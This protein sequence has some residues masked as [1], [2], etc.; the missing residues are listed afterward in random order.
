MRK[1]E[2]KVKSKT[3]P[4]F[5]R[6]ECPGPEL[7]HA[8]LSP[9]GTLP[10]GTTLLRIQ[11]STRSRFMRL[12]AIK[13]TKASG[14]QTHSWSRAESPGGRLLWLRCR[15]LGKTVPGKLASEGSLPLTAKSL[16]ATTV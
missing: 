13:D 16:S 15:G 4:A 12:I 1:G 9:D 14:S 2:P 5:K 3:G 11:H 6:G 8:T 7:P 10:N